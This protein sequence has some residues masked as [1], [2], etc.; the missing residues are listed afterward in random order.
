MGKTLYELSKIFVEHAWHV[1]KII[2]VSNPG[3]TNYALAT[4]GSVITIGLPIK[5]CS[6]AKKP[7]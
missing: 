5:G 7:V 1:A 6:Q 4:A 2:I 3:L